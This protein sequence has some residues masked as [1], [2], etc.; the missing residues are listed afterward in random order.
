[1][2]LVGLYLEWSGT[3]CAV[4]LHV[5]ASVLRDFKTSLESRVSG[6]LPKW[7]QLT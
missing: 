5:R 6:M 2:L 1:M 4:P 3:T 7:T